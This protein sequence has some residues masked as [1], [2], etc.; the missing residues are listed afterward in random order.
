MK[1][2]VVSHKPCV[3]S[4]TSSTGYA[5]DGGF[6]VQMKALSELFSST[7]V[8]VPCRAEVSE[9]TAPIEGRGLEVIPLE[10]MPG[11]GAERRLRFPQWLI[12]NAPRIAREIAQ[13][14]VV[15]AMIPGDVGTL[16]FT[17][18]M[19]QGKRLFVRHCGNWLVTRTF[20]E[21]AWR[22]AM[23]SFASERRLMFATGGAAQPPSANPHVRWIFSTSLGLAE[24]LSQGRL[25]VAL[26]TRL[27][28]LIA[29]RQEA[30]K[31]TAN[32]IEALPLLKREG[33]TF[34]LDVVGDGSQLPLLRARVEALGL[35]SAVTFHGQLPRVDVLSMM[36]QAHLFCLPTQSEGFP[37]VV[38]EAMACGVPVITTSVSVLPH[39]LKDGGGILLRDASPGEIARGVLTA[40]ESDEAWQT[41]SN[42]AVTT[43]QHYSIESWKAHLSTQ[44]TAHWGPLLHRGSAFS[45][46]VASLS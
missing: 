3:V 30:G 39:L 11:V 23:E 10:F 14:D 38:L 41:L 12:R 22:W 44:L 18:A 34:Y 5:T 26:R 19:L 9:G 27:R 43:A 7:R 16:G 21:H 20:A 15:H 35:Q 6:P 46:G 40:T 17:L 24:M 13:A 32:L 36:R 25:E 1:L 31:G 33:L 29:C 4:S 8:L 42:E 45:A 28:L 2:V 37:K